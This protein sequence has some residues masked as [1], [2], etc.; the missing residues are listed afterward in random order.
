[1]NNNTKIG[2]EREKWELNWDFP[3]CS[4]GIEKQNLSHWN[5]ESHTTKL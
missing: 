2:P 5:W 3:I 4:R 1:M